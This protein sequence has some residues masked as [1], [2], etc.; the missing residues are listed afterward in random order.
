MLSDRK[1]TAGEKLEM[2]ALQDWPREVRR[3]ITVML[4][5]I[6][7]T[8]TTAGAITPDA[9]AALGALKAAGLSVI[10]VTGRPSGWSEPFALEWPVDAIVAENGAVAFLPYKKGLLRIYSGRKLLLKVYQ[11]DEP[12]RARNCRANAARVSRK[13]WR[14]C[15]EQ[16]ARLHQ[17]GTALYEAHSVAV[18]NQFDGL[19]RAHEFGVA[20]ARR[21]RHCP[22]A[23]PSFSISAFSRPKVSCAKRL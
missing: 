13:W 14:P 2:H 19:R 5:D 23:S 7:D 22:F 20:P 18:A 6:D 11:Q 9:L 16:A 17:A 4:T 15:F 1:K 3:R 21:A 8:L 12:T 10:A